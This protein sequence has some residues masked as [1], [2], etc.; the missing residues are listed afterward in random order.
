FG[1]AFFPDKLRAVREMCRV[2][3]PGGHV[4]V[5]W[6]TKDAFQPMDDMATARLEQYGVPR[7]PA[8]PEPWLALK[9]PEH[10]LILLEKGGGRE[11]RVQREA[12]G[13]FITPEDW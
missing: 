4:A 2:L 10:L 9:E 7:P 12:A 3:R 8:P 1:V 6:W 11:R 13:Y 5:S